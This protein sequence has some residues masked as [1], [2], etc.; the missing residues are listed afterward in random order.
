MAELFHA[1]PTLSNHDDVQP[2]RRAP[3]ALFIPVPLPSWP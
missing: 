3:L 1:N 2:T